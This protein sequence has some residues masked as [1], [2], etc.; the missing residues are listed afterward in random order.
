MALTV[1]LLAGSFLAVPFYSGDPVYAGG[2]EDEF[3]AVWVATVFGLNYPS[4][5]TT[6][7]EVLKADALAILDNCQE[8]G[9]NTVILQVRPASDSLYDSDIF[10]W[11]MYLTGTQGQAPDGGFDPLEFWIKEA[12]KRGMDL[13]A[14][15]NPYRIT[16]AKGDEAKLAADHPALVHPDWTVLH[17]DGKLYWDPGHPGAQ[18]LILEGVS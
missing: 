13:H 7:P 12:H 4:K 3:R 1:L 14:W 6:D 17:T 15:L 5:K 10:P 9:F 18:N 16:A 2:T 8:M 11:S